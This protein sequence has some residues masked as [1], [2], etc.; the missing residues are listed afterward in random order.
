MVHYLFLLA[1][2]L[3]LCYTAIIQWPAGHYLFTI[4]PLASPMLHC[5]LL[6]AHLISLWYTT[7]SFWPTGYLNGTL[8]FPTANWLSIWYTTLSYKPTGYL[9]D[10]QKSSTGPL[11]ISMVHYYLL[12]AHWIYQ[13]T[14]P[15]PFGPLISQRYT[16]PSNWPTGYH[17]GTPLSS[18][19]PLGISMVP[20]PHLLA[21]LLSL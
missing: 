16:T 11:D 15:S 18:S 1:H 6:L 20:Y 19:G 12:L 7:L 14:L 2:W 4:G 5:Y 17:Y 9:Y 8:S 21:D 13:G 10:S 3:S